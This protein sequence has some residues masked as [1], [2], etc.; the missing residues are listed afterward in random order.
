MSTT[1][2]PPSSTDEHRRDHDDGH[3]PGG[4]LDVFGART[5]IVFAF[6]AVPRRLRVRRAADAAAVQSLRV[7]R[8]EIDSLML[9]ADA[10]AAALTKVFEGGLLL[11]LFSLGHSLEHYAM[12][13]AKRA[14]EALAELAPKTALVRRDSEEIDVAVEDLAVGDTVIVRPNSRIPADGFVV[15]GV[16]Q[17]PITGESVPVDKQPVDD[18]SR[19]ADAP[20]GV[21]PESRVFS[22]TIN[23]SG[24]F[25]LRVTR[26]AADNT[27]ARVVQLVSEA[28]TGQ[29]STQQFTDRFERSF[30]PAVILFVVGLAVSPLVTGE[31]S[32]R[33]VLPRHGGPRRSESVRA[34][35]RHA[36]RRPHRGRPDRPQRRARQGGDRSRTSDPCRRSRSTRRAPSP[37]AAP[38]H[39]RGRLRPRPRNP[40]PPG[41]HRGRAAQRPPA[42]PCD[43]PGRRRPSHRAAA[44]GL[45]A[46]EHH[47]ARRPG[48][49]RRPPDP[50]R[51]ARPLRRGGRSPPPAEIGAF[52]EGS[53][54]R[55]ARR[56]S[57]VTATS[58]SASPA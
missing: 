57:S 16:D 49:T 1:A 40:A 3:G 31:D 34:G 58:T 12:G 48:D 18:P 42:R 50:R 26:R 28:E 38:P 54:P 23:G 4:T 25:D 32:R 43:R 46:A 51:Q 2:S 37:R 17:A 30:V 7:G 14:I 29:S 20:D 47:R 39:R 11:F 56:C 52:V 19:A 6:P 9:V 13:R 15:R 10:G 21:A 5:E 55:G 45:R 22:G 36:Q 24:A 44:Y 33:R 8:F 27:L 53:M 41:R 35:H